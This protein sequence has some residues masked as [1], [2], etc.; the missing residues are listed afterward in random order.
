MQK[1]DR[2][3]LMC[4]GEKALKNTTKNFKTLWDGTDPIWN[5]LKL[6]YNIL[7]RN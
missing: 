5:I 6:F 3:P 4:V 7:L 1:K 2:K